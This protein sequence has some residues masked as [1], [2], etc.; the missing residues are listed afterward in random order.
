MLFWD[1]ADFRSGDGANQSPVIPA[2]ASMVRHHD[3]GRPMSA[4]S[5][6]NPR[7]AFWFCCYE[8]ALNAA[9]F[10]ALLEQLMHKRKRAVHLVIE[11]LPAH[12]KAMVR[13][14][15]E[16][17]DGRLSLHFLPGHAPAMTGD[18]AARSGIG[19]TDDRSR[20]ISGPQ[21]P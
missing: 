3:P 17:T 4:A 2:H 21:H 10:V 15:V 11:D 8:G 13:K 6:V 14:Y 20:A 19:R 12:R 5:A 16:S 18:E 9:L 1:E 7:G